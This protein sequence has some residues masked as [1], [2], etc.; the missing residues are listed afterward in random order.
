MS[1]SW[2][3][4]GRGSVRVTPVVAWAAAALVD[5]QS[6][7]LLRL[8]F[9]LDPENKDVSALQVAFTEHQ[10]REISDK[11]KALADTISPGSHQANSSN[12]C[13]PTES[14]A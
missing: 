5:N 12:S 14:A 4:D 1:N 3:K 7:I 13:V 8:E 2:S 11:L 6:D 10:A 9:S